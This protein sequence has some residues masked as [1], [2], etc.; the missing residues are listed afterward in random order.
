MKFCEGK[1]PHY[2]DLL[3][4]GIGLFA[5]LTLESKSGMKN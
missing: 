2:I 1:K 4:F 3:A 5:L